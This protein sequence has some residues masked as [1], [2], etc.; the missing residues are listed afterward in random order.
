[1]ICIECGDRYL[2]YDDDDT[3]SS[4]EIGTCDLCDEMEEQ[5]LAEGDYY[6][7]AYLEPLY[8]PPVKPDAVQL[9]LPI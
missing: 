1:M 6:H 4:N 3:M 9:T 5:R 7:P 2:G 8:D